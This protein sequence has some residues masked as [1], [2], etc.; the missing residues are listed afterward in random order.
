MYIIFLL[1]TPIVLMIAAR[2]GWKYVLGG[3]S[4][5]W[6]LAQF[7]LRQTAYNVGR[8]IAA[9]PSHSEMGSFD[10]WAWQFLWM[11]GLWF[12]VG[13]AKGNLRIEPWAR[14]YH[15]RAGDCSR[16]PGPALHGRSW[17]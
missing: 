2:V 10:L 11:L 16:V 3:S 14:N 9:S 17:R 8:R 6:L 5:L 13:W 7:G 1:L 4:I 15:P 12:G